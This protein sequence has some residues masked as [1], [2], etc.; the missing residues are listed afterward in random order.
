MKTIHY[1]SLLLGLAV[2]SIGCSQNDELSAYTKNGGLTIIATADGFTSTDNGQTRTADDGYSTTFSNG[3]QIGVFAT[4]DG[5]VVVNN[6]VCTYYNGQWTG[7]VIHREGATYFAYYPYRSEMDGKTSVDN[8]VNDFEV[9]TDQSTKELYTANDLMTATG[10]ISDMNNKKLLTLTFG[11]ALSL[12][13]FRLIVKAQRRYTL[14][15]GGDYPVTDYY[16]CY[17]DVKSKKFFIDSSEIKPYFVNG[18]YRYLT[19]AGKEVSFSGEFGSRVVSD[20]EKGKFSKTYTPVKGI[21]KKL[22]LS[23]TETTYTMR[24]LTFGDYYYSDGSICPANMEYPPTENCIG[25]IYCTEKSFMQES[26]TNKSYLHG[27]VVALN[28]AY[29]DSCKWENAKQYANNYS[30]KRPDSSSGWYFPNQKE[31]QYMAQKETNGTKGTDILEKQF[32]KL[33]KI[34]TGLNR[35]WRGYWTSTEYEERYFWYYRVEFSPWDNGSKWYNR[36]DEKFYSR[37]SLAF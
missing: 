13:E 37:S 20:P 26:G 24:S 1:M 6:V 14:F 27:L 33:G 17:L 9:A 15:I 35:T 25:V 22:N 30:V 5:S 2:V 21:Y 3:D 18:V 12:V 11:H 16:M 7:D 28:D 31:M 4:L 29:S 34:A 23:Y 36:Y 32:K 19:K 10:S 8:I